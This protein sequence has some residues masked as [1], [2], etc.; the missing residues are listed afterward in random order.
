VTRVCSLHYISSR[1]VEKLILGAIRRVS[2]YALKNE[3]DFINKI[4]EASELRQENTVKEN[5]KLLTKSKQRHEDLY[6]LIKKLYEGN[7]SGKI[8]DKHFEKLLAEYDTEQSE[9]ETK[10]KELQI[11]IEDY[12][13]DSVRVD[14][15]MELA[16]RYTDFHEL[17]TPMLNEFVDKI[18][19]HEGD[20]T[21]GKRVQRVDIYFNFIGDFTV[22]AEYDEYTQEE[23]AAIEAEQARLDKKN[24]YENERRRKKRAAA[25]SSAVL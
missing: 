5:K 15:F 22:P 2:S 24:T 1:A 12:N 9:L 20:K 7:A 17:T 8:P 4:R 23:R 10:I 18:I 21:S 25:V 6:G 13:A 19:V 3:S 11:G 14:S 16:R